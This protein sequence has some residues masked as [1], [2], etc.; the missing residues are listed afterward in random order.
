PARYWYHRRQS[1]FLNRG[2]ISLSFMASRMS[3]GTSHRV[4]QTLAIREHTRARSEAL[5]RALPPHLAGLS[6]RLRRG[7]APAA[8]PPAEVLQ[9]D[10]RVLPKVWVGQVVSFRSEEHTS[11]LQSRSDLVC[12][13]L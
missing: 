11:E 5:R 2:E 9:P 12:R 13:L 3:M 7:I 4:T 10:S 6:L 1:S 8:R